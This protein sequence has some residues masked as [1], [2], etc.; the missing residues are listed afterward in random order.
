[1]QG[2]GKPEV[3]KYRKAYMS[4]SE[5]VLAITT[6]E[7]AEKTKVSKP[8]VLET[9]KTLEEANLIKRRVGAIMISAKLVHRDNNEKERYL[10]TRFYSFDNKANADKAE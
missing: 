1:M 5:N 2:I 4:K 10:M 8:V 6:K 9:L 3:L 7:L